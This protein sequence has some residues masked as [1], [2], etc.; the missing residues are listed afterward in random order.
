MGQ[1]VELLSWVERS[2][3]RDYCREMMMRV[4]IDYWT[5]CYDPVPH[6][7]HDRIRM[8]KDHHWRCHWDR[9]HRYLYDEWMVAN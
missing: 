2:A 7:R 5:S 4:I 3:S 6:Y 8:I 1:V 9:C